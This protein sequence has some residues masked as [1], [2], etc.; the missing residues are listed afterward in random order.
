MFYA[1]SLAAVIQEG[2]RSTGHVHKLQSNSII[3]STNWTNLLQ[4]CTR[5]MSICH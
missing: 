5:S 3:T 4:L 2:S 1:H